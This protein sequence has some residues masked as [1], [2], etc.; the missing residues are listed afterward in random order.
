MEITFDVFA[1]ALEQQFEK[2]LIT[3]DQFEQNLTTSDKLIKGGKK[4][5]IGERRTFGGRE[6][7]KTASG[8]KFH[9]KGTGKKDQEHAKTS[10]QAIPAAK[11][12]SAKSSQQEEAFSVL[13]LLEKHGIRRQLMSGQPAKKG[14]KDKPT[15][16]FNRSEKGQDKIGDF[17]ES[18]IE[19]GY[20][21]KQGDHSYDSVYTKEGEDIEVTY[22][23]RL[24]SGHSG[25]SFTK[26]EEEVKEQPAMDPE[27]ATKK[28]KQAIKSAISTSARAQYERGMHI[29]DF[30]SVD[31]SKLEEHFGKPVSERKG[32]ALNQTVY[33]HPANDTHIV[34]NTRT[35]NGTGWITHQKD[36][37]KI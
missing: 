12:E 30:N 3:E 17:V 21:R 23:A 34:V 19:A 13:S 32:E 5:V 20:Q 22:H 9:G 25:L 16:Y 8:W 4:A 2:G 11:E 10:K 35:R 18:L 33:K 36:L 15:G 27:K 6:Y 28:V 31:H 1:K 37:S 24:G 29:H 7:V 26:R 14:E